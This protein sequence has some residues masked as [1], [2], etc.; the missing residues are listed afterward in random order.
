MPLSGRIDVGIAVSARKQRGTRPYHHGDLR[1]AL[2]RSALAILERSGLDAL[3]L[4]AIAADV[5]VSHAAPAH[6][7]GTLKKL[8]NALA[9][10]GYE[11]FAEA[12]REHR[13]KASP[14]PVAQMR[15]ASDGYLAFAL[16][17]PA[18]FRL[19]FS[20]DLL[21]WSDQDLKAPAR[22][23]RRQLEEIC[24]PAAKR[25]GMAPGTAARLALERLVWSDIHG[26]AHLVIDRQFDPP[27][28]TGSELDIAALIH[29][30]DPARAASPSEEA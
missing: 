23:A 5:G 20:A 6:H 26:R 10:I 19:M 27:A 3:T 15:A 8:R 13:A 18:L 17:N 1:N 29:G 7:F 24:A 4:R 16:A 28:P 25:L 2:I 9:A 30:Y 22:L 14:D 21:D 11:R 12:M